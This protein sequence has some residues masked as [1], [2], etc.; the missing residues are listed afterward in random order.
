MSR[1]EYF[2]CLEGY[3][4]KLSDEEREEAIQYYRDYFD[5]AGPEK[6]EE[7]ISK[8]GSPKDLAESI[9]QSERNVEFTESGLNDSEKKEYSPV[10]Y[11]AGKANSNSSTNSSNTETTK[12]N[13]N[14][15]LMVVLIILCIVFSPA[16]LSLLGGLC[17]IAISLICAGP[18][19]LI[20]AVSVLI[21]GFVS[22]FSHFA[23]G[24]LLIGVGLLL[25]GLGMLCLSGVI[26]ICKYVIPMLWNGLK[27][28][29]TSI[30]GKKEA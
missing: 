13:D 10:S 4:R 26:A 20:A 5:E 8:L 15:A 14:T 9:M 25:A 3:L 18:A 19:L 23:L 30:T 21:V 27:K 28:L 1:E 12:K 2:M 6:E 22:I 11:D 16:I 24:I 17:G 29:W 7:I